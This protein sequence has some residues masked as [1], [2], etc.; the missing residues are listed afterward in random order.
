M[1]SSA[2]IQE[3]LFCQERYPGGIAGV[4]YLALQN[5][6]CMAHT[7]LMRAAGVLNI[8]LPILIPKGD[9]ESNT[10]KHREC[11]LLLVSTN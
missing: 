2:R 10:P 7:W 9:C 5:L 6:L 4:K 3:A 11:R 8:L 1:T